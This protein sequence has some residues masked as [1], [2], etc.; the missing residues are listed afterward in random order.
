MRARE[1][2]ERDSQEPFDTLITSLIGCGAQEGLGQTA[3]AADYRVLLR[4]AAESI[5]SD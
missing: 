3:K 5:T 4:E 1:K 2:V